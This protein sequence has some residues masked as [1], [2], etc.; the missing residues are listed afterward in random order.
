M[1]KKKTV[2]IDLKQYGMVIALI[3][4]FFIFYFMSG[5]KNASPTN[6][7]NLVMQNGYV[8]ILAV[9]MLLCV[10][11]GNVDLGVG[12]I[13][14]LCGAVAAILVVDKGAAVPVA[15]L[16]ALA[17]GLASGAF[18]GFFISILNIP[19]FVVTP[20]SYTHLDVYKRQV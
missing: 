6:I 11:T 13:V 3:A 20:V 18:A 1:D 9:G 17:I 12:S 5:G 7:N 16:A 8:V 15:F 4:I 19:P 10:L 14:A 2:N